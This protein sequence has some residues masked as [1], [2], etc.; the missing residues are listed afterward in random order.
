MKD[1]EELE[2]S[3]EPPLDLGNYVVERSRQNCL[4]KGGFG[5]VF[6]GHRKETE[7]V[8]AVKE[9]E[10]NNSTQK[11][12]ARE[13][14]FM[15][16]CTHENI[17]RFIDVKET[18]NFVFIIM[19]YCPQGNMNKFMLENEISFEKC[20]AFM[21]NVTDAI[22]YL[23]NEKDICHRDVKPDNVLVTN[24]GQCAKLAD[25]GLAR[26]FASS[27]SAATGTGV[28]TQGWLAPETLKGDDEDDRSRFSP[29]SDI[30]SLG[31]LFLAMLLA[32]PG[33]AHLLPYTGMYKISCLVFFL[34]EII[35]NGND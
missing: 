2:E 17:V 1:S 11:F 9:I 24:S 21:M 22:G 23:H 13:L 16:I 14:S 25:F 15:R 31:L 35:S 3:T 28:G 26:L 20:T 10:R 12:I 29:Q 8:V 4:G 5:R 30:F 32:L 7:E 6:K 18:P 27:A 34:Q 19:E 33:K